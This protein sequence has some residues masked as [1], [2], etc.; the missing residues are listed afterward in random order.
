[1]GEG[2]EAEAARW[3]G[4]PQRRDCGKRRRGRRT[5]KWRRRIRMQSERRRERRKGQWERRERSRGRDYLRE[6]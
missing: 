1:M 2:S 4:D 5:A 6:G 3:R